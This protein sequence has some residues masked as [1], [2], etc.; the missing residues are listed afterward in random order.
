MSERYKFNDP[1]G[2]YFVTLSIVFWIDL[3]TRK[4]LKHLLINSLKHCQKEKGLVI[5]SWCLMPSHVHLI[6]SSEDK[7]LAHI[8]RDFKKYTAKSIVRTI[9]DIKESRGIWLLNAFQKAG[10]NLKRVSEYKV[11]QDGNHA[12]ELI[13][14]KFKDQ[15]LHYIHQNPVKAEIVDEPEY[16][17]YS[18]ARDYAGQKGLLDIEF[19]D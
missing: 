14:N 17:W 4:E 10:K 15:K 3:F 11:W 19:L 18:S 8:L 9:P 5:Y 7:P 13:S 16:Y 12:E 6:I 2:I 1:E